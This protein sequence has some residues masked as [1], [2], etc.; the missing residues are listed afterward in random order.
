MAS[1]EDAEWYWEGS[2]V[3]VGW[4]EGAVAFNVVPLETLLVASVWLMAS[5]IAMGAMVVLDRMQIISVMSVLKLGCDEAWGVYGLY[6][7]RG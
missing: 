1:L 7:S 4:N 5:G 3:P 6:F 2:G